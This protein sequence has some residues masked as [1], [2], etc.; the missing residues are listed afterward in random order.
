MKLFLTGASGFVGAET[1]RQAVECGYQVVAPVSPGSV[2]PR[3]EHLAGRF[4]RLDLDLRNSLA[5]SSAVQQHRPDVVIHLAWTGVANSARFD[6]CQFVDNLEPSCTLV[7]AAAAAGV[8]TFIGMGS[9]GEYGP[10]SVMSEDSLPKPTSLYGAAKV[11]ALYLTRQ[12]ATQAG[13]RHAWVRLFSTYGPGDNDVWLIPT[14]IN[15]ML[16][17]RRPRTTLGTQRWDWLHVEDAARALLAVAT[18]S[19]ASGVFNLGSGRSERVRD[20]IERIRDLT[21]PDMELVFGEIP[22]RPDQ[23][24]LMQ[25][26]ITRLQQATGWSPQISMQEGLEG[27]VA[28]HRQM[29][30]AQ[31]QLQ[32]VKVLS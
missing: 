29:R 25:A 7:E 27:T 4:L 13:M 19:A 20:V 1:L 22:F 11:A 21:A 5:L 16:S 8:G 30:G 2:S 9:Q 23:V 18:T 6:R 15:E 31:K 26:D 10:G 12:I 3:L 32:Q 28:W 17:G 24:M 14:L